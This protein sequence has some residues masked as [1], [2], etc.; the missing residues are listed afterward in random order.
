MSFSYEPLLSCTDF[1]F[2]I[3]YHRKSY[4][5]AVAYDVDGPQD[6][7]IVTKF[8]PK[9]YTE[10]RHGLRV[11][12]DNRVKYDEDLWTRQ[13]VNGVERFDPK[14]GAYFLFPGKDSRTCY[15]IALLEQCLSRISVGHMT[16]K[17]IVEI[18]NAEKVAP[19]EGRLLEHCLSVARTNQTSL[20]KSWEQKRQKE[21]DRAVKMAEDREELLIGREQVLFDHAVYI[22]PAV[23]C[24]M[25]QTRCVLVRIKRVI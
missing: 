14:P 19:V 2:H 21:V 24:K 15:S 7:L 20:V 13:E 17:S 9:C 8:C 25:R 1:L 22:C 11:C 10:Y 6:A 5:S 3:A 18:Y 12:P 23:G 16:F 4:I